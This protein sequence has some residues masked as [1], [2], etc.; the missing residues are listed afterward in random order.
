MTF[1]VFQ[2]MFPLLHYWEN[3]TS[4]VTHVM[5]QAVTHLMAS[6]TIATKQ[7]DTPCHSERSEESQTESSLL[8]VT[9]NDVHAQLDAIG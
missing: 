4:T 9:R 6:Y 5:T 8:S 1:V 3:H 2:G 7:S